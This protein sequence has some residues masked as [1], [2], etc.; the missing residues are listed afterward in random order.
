MDV[1]WIARI[2]ST[3]KKQDQR[4]PSYNLNHHGTAHSLSIQPYK[5]ENG[6]KAVQYMRFPNG[7]AGR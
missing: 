7:P 6:L 4:L 5:M 3:S 2:S 1:C